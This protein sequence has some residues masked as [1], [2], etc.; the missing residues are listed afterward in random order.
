MH[1]Y[2]GHFLCNSLNEDRAEANRD[3]FFFFFFT[4]SAPVGGPAG[5]GTLFSSNWGIFSP[6][7]FHKGTWIESLF[8]LSASLSPFLLNESCEVFFS[9]HLQILNLSFHSVIFSKSP[10]NLVCLDSLMFSVSFLSDL[11]VGEWQQDSNSGHTS[12]VLSYT[13]ALNNPLGPKTAPVVE[14]Q[15]SL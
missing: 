4:V 9:F 7:F 2:Y 14:T 1:A 3:D 12:R 10:G 13:I 11:S 5:L 15:V 6:L 8:S